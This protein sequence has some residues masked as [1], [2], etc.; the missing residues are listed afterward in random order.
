MDETF[1]FPKYL[2]HTL[3]TPRE[4]ADYVVFC[5]LLNLLFA[6]MLVYA[7]GS[8]LPDLWPFIV[9]GIAFLLAGDAVLLFVG[10]GLYRY[11]DF[12]VMGYGYSSDCVYNR[13]GMT[14]RRIHRG[15][16][17][18]I[19]KILL[20]QGGSHGHYQARFIALWKEED[21]PVD[22]DFCILQNL[23]DRNVLL[24]KDD[25]SACNALGEALG[26]TEIPEYPQS[27]R[28]AMQDRLNSLFYEVDGELRMDETP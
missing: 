21:Q 11:K 18:F 24:F 16:T 2:R 13:G 9:L 3:S 8:V 25:A 27:R 5:V 12:Y 10:R 17:F 4:I 15:D 14:D 7:F 6:G 22:P 1:I 26:V 20:K 19:T 23:I 28:Y